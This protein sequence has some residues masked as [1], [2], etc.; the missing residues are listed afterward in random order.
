MLPMLLQVEICLEVLL[1][2]ELVRSS[3]L[4]GRFESFKRLPLR[5]LLSQL[6]AAAVLEP[7]RSI[8]EHLVEDLIELHPFV[9]QVLH[10]L[11]QE[12]LDLPD[13]A[14]LGA[15]VERL[16]LLLQAEGEGKQIAVVGAQLADNLVVSQDA[17]RLVALNQ[18][19]QFLVRF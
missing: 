17:A 6:L 11:D 2:F 14:L 10:R 15:G 1:R 7:P 18:G 8:A 9:V 19:G 16:E 3:L 4:D 5:Q 13:L 12:L